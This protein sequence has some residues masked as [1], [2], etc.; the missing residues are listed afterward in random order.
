V[1]CARTAADLENAVT[2]AAGTGGW[3]V[4]TFHE[5]SIDDCPSLAASPNFDVT[6][7]TGKNPP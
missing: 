3:L 4:L 1:T 2:D 5:L 6:V 7:D